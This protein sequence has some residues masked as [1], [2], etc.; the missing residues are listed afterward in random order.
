L[1]EVYFEL[2]NIEKD[3]LSYFKEYYNSEEKRTC[4]KCGTIMETNPKFVDK[5]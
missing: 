1:H 5:K 3:F 2:H 4:E